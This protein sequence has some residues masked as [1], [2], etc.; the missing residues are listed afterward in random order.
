MENLNY[1]HLRYFWAVARGGNLT[2]AAAD[3]HLTPQTVSTQ[4]KDL[5]RALGE[6]LFRRSGRR[7]VL[8]DVGQ[9]VYR[10]AD[11]IFSIG[12]ELVETLA[13]QTGGRTLRLVVGVADN[14]PKMVA[15]RLIE[16][17]TCLVE[18]VRVVCR[19]TGL[20]SLLA[21]LAVHRVD[22]VLSDAPIPPSIKV[23]AFNHLLGECGV[24]FMMS[25][26]L[27]RGFQHKFPR[28]LDG[29]PMLLPSEGTALRGQLDQWFQSRGIYPKIV[30][31]F[32]DSAL[33]KTFGQAGAGAF[34]VP[35]V[36]EEEVARQYNVKRIGVVDGVV[37]RY[38]AI[39][40]ERR[41]K[42]PAV[43]AICESARTELF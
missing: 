11:E 39:S 40:V 41:V 30:G 9:V 38:Y 31:E 12:K 24:S 5:E 34:P 10:Y 18:P 27:A 26:R 28:S 17:A 21:D 29:A 42:H 43:A 36:V 32:E 6:R 23:R 3:L 8:T 2:R 4:I 1:H 25:S 16:P 13:G 35:S 19:E 14:L 22:V 20:Q 33:L 15:Y 7:L 37:E